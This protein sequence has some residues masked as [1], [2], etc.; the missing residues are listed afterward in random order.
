MWRSKLVSEQNSTMFGQLLHADNETVASQWL[1]QSLCTWQ[2]HNGQIGTDK[3]RRSARPRVIWRILTNKLIAQKLLQVTNA[4]L[5]ERLTAF[6]SIILK[7]MAKVES[8]VQIAA[9]TPLQSGFN[10]SPFFGTNLE[11]FSA[12]IC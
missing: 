4:V 9:G 7:A 2:K 12:V 3:K 10:H 11:A 8:M 1:N 5:M 6:A